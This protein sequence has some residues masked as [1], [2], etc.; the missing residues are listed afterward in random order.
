MTLKSSIITA[1]FAVAAICSLAL[2]ASAGCGVCGPKVT[3]N[4]GGFGGGYGQ[5]TGNRNS[6]SGASGSSVTKGNAQIDRRGRVS[7]DLSVTSR[8][9]A[10]AYGEGRNN[11]ALAVA[12][13]IAG[14]EVKAKA[15]RR[16]RP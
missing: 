15:P 14:G 13:S 16:R 6:W 12:G 1:G 3:F 10:D 11:S 8:G 9:A 2:Q 7:G 5:S 4:G